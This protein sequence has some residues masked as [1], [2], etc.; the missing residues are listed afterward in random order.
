M[1]IYP[2]SVGFGKATTKKTVAERKRIKRM[3]VC[4]KVRDLKAAGKPID[5]QAINEEVRNMVCRKRQGHG[6]KHGA[7][8][9]KAAAK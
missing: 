7:Q 3:M 4:K 6:P 5:L 1:P 2:D 8:A 9:V